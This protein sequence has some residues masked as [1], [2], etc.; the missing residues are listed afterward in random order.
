MDKH[1]VRKRPVERAIVLA[2]G[3][4][5]RLVADA[6]FPKPLKPVGGVS[7]LVRILRSLACEGVREAVIVVGYQG[8]QIRAALEGDRS[9]GLDVTFVDNP[10]WEK[11]NG[12]SLL[13]AAEF[14]DRDCLLTM[15][16][17][18]FSPDIARR[19][20]RADLPVGSCALGVDYDVAECFDI[21]DATK[22]VVEAGR[23]ARIG[24]DLETYNAIDTGV[25]R[26]GPSLIRALESVER[27]RGDASLSDGVRL[28]AQKGQFY[29]TDIGD[30]RWIDVDTPEAHARAEAMVRLFGDGL[31]E[32][33]SGSPIIDAEAME[34]FAPSWVRGAPPYRDTHF[35]VADG[36][37]R[38]RRTGPRRPMARLMSN[39]SPFAPSS[40]VVDAVMNAL[41]RG[42]LYPD[43]ALAS[44][45]RR[46]IASQVDLPEEAC[47]LGAGSSEII[48]LVVRTF[49]SPGEEVVIAVPTFSMYE[50]RARVAGGVPMLVAM[51]DDLSLDVGAVLGAVT[52]RTKLIFLCTPNNPTG[53]RPEENDLR[54]ILRL[55]LPTVLD[56][57][58]MDF[59]DDQS[60]AS[61]LL[62]EYPNAIVVRTFSKAHGLAGLRIGY[63][64]AHV[65]VARLLSRVK[66]PWNVSGIAL[67]AAL[68][69]LDDTDEFA[70]RRD[71]VRAERAWM[72]RQFASIPSVEVFGGEGNFV[73]LDIHETGLTADGVVQAMLTEGVLIRSLASH[74]LRR[75]YVRVSVGGPEENRRC[76]E[77]LRRTLQRA[78]P[79]VRPTAAE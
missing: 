33:P 15:A 28:L 43:A 23:I 39:E 53:I 1:T 68:A 62:H 16:D 72:I 12:V 63:A 35:A 70:R 45:L 22:V 46:R 61:T 55:G 40:R 34:L 78:R 47:V 37:V 48:D 24:K 32:E 41:S 29:A 5:S 38:P 42:H 31:G 14:V 25:F 10:L 79:S 71:V 50:S 73:L 18:L 20:V 6:S 2:A 7:L 30:A 9:L 60:N 69:S 52:E 67:A 76:V 57:A 64:L 58:Y 75:G 19:L 65:P 66:L 49:V 4:G 44:E 54:R 56:E 74:H 8:D 77:T 17:H 13:Q 27:E 59:E 21:D 3:R 36:N 11:S 51:N 26:I